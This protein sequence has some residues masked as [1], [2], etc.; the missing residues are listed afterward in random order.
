MALTYCCWRAV[1]AT[2]AE[3]KKQ[4][5][6]DIYEALDIRGLT[7]SEVSGGTHNDANSEA[8]ESIAVI[9]F[10]RVGCSKNS[11]PTA[12]EIMSANEMAQLVGIS[13]TTLI[14]AR[15]RWSKKHKERCPG[16]PAQTKFIEPSMA[17]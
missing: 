14:A 5:M 4:I 7:L 2:P 10:E 1:R 8:R 11:S 3:T 9:L 13:R 17:G 6:C 16:L 12:G 15:K